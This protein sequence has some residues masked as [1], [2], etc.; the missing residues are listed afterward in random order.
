MGD[1]VTLTLHLGVN[2]LPYAQGPIAPRRVVHRVTKHGAVRTFTAAS[3]GQQTTGDVAEIL[4]DKY[5]I[6]ETFVETYREE[7]GDAV[8]HSIAGAIENMVAGSPAIENPFAT[9]EN[10]IEESMKAFLDLQEM[11][12]IPG[13][14]T[15]A[16]LRGKSKR[17]KRNKGAPRPSFEDSG[18]MQANYRAQFEQT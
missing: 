8:A 17:F 4:E 10:E 3:S 7:I 2:D 12:G 18:L 16:A 5:H 9:A 15:A 11:D 14:P 1:V 6:L 13:V